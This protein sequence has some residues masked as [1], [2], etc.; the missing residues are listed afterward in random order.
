MTQ[1]ADAIVVG[2]GING[3]VAAAELAQAGWSVIL[4]ERNAEIGGF[5]AT[6]ERTLPGYLH[7]TFS[8]WHPMFV[9]GL[10]YGALG[11][12]LHQHGLEYRNTDKWLMASVADDG[13]VTLAHRDPERTVAEF[14]HPE[15]RSAYCTM[16]QRLGENR[17][18]IGGLLT[19]EMRSLA[20]VRH[21]SDLIQSSG[22]RRAEWWLRAAATSGRGY[23]RRDFRGDEV[24]HLYAPWL[25]HAGL[26]P[27]NAAGGLMTSLFA[28]TLH[29]AGL[30]VVAGG[31]G[32][33]LAAFD[34]LLASLQVQ[35]ETGCEVERIVVENGRA[36][37][38]ETAG[39]I[40]RARRAVLAS[41]TPSALYSRLLPESAIDSDLRVEA[42]RFRHG[43]AALQVHVALSQPLGWTDSRLEQVPLI[44]LSDGSASTGIAC[45]EAEAG[46]L[47]RQP[48]VVVGQQYLLDPGRVPAGAAALWLQLQEVPFA[49]RGDSA[50][51][52]DTTHG[53]TAALAEGYA[54]RVLDRIGRHAPDLRSKIRAF[55]VLTPWDLHARNPNAVNG[56]PYGGSAELDQSFLWRPLA[57]LG[58]HAT[59]VD[60]LWHIGASTHPGP[61]L[62]GGSGHL[63]ATTLIRHAERGRLGDE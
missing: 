12:M 35:I 52:L 1:E 6:E 32:R 54:N 13:R 60:R 48:T 24:D 9:T 10:A 19:S 8:S 27:D 39:R 63:V 11:E 5:I 47:P 38:V 25:L 44:H 45:A 22:L 55:D 7:D 40:L 17:E 56:D 49:P 42:A 28:A 43:R 18:S 16:L 15:D 33:F 29:G 53:W 61:G 51:E 37:G 58:S 14:T 41:V 30:P 62:S 2:S 26:S 31:A 57:S 50:G 46:L 4:I 20:L 59:P 3:L 36:I 23:A 34:S 21:I